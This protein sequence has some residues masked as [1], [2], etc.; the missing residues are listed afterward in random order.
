MINLRGNN[1]EIESIS[2]IIFDKDGTISNSHIYWSE[3]IKMRADII[4]KRY[5]LNDDIHSDLCE[6]MG[7]DI[8]TNLLLPNGPIAL[9]S[10]DE[11]IIKLKKFLEK[12]NIKICVKEIENIFQEVHHSFS[13]KLNNYIKPI[14]S[15]IN[16]IK[17]LSQYKVKLSLITSDSTKNANLVLKKLNLDY[18]F[19]YV[20]GGD[21]NLERKSTGEP[22]RFVCEKLNLERKNVIAIGDA[23]MDLQMSIN[24]GLLDCILVASG[25]TPLKKLKILTPNC[26]HS[27]DEIE[28]I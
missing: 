13:L 28:I 10:R 27:L 7:L 26:V 15:A 24:A 2:G 14:E 3:I 1:F 16:L 19:D 20:I 9:K 5:K 22:A 25:Q 8:N 12:L 21:A 23:A 4:C 11:V 17:K 6:S 18:F